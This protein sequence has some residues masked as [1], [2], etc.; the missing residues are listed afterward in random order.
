[1][2]NQFYYIL[3][4]VLLL[5]LSSCTSNDNGMVVSVSNSLDVDRTVETVRVELCESLSVATGVVVIDKASNVEIQ[6]QL[7][8]KD[9]DNVFEAILFQVKLSAN[10]SRDFVI[11]EGV[12]SVKPSEV[13]T[14]A[15][16]VPE[17]T[18]D[19]TWE[20]DKVAFRVYGPTAQRM[21]EE[22]Q[23][24][25]TLSGGVDCWLKKVDYSI[26]NKWYKGNDENPGYYHID[27]GEGL[28]NYHVGPSL[29]CGGTGVMIDGE[30][31]TSLNYT[32]YNVLSNGPV[33]TAFEL[34]YAPFGSEKKQVSQSKTGIINLGNNFTKFVIEV[35]GADTLTTGVTLHEN[36]GVT[37]VDSVACWGDYWSP[38][39]GEEIGNAIV[40]DPKYYAGYS[41]VVSN[42]K[43]KSHLLM[44]LKVIDGKVEYYTGFAWSGSKQFKGQKE[45][46]AYLSKFAR[47]ISN[48][49]K[50]TKAN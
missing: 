1:M 9:K 15:R 41:K 8:D 45:W 34:A 30:L 49:L 12:S 36:Q 47:Q 39:F 33:E 23:E 26:I 20:N 2:K 18:D 46:E 11:K 35:K 17:R 14:Y 22:G 7:V 37:G 28:D 38:H 44:H 13:K 29:G 42:E 6:S 31:V 48:P 4:A 50:I 25:G 3:F 10:E 43:D 5:V 40:V 27:H 19:F 16:F 24:G 21:V 32:G